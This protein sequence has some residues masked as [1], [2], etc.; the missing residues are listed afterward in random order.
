MKKL[1]IIALVFFLFSGCSSVEHQV[2][3]NS[4]GGTTIEK[5]LIPNGKTVT[6]PID[7]LKDGY[8]FICWEL[9]NKEFNFSTKVSKDLILTAKWE[10]SNLKKYKVTFD[11]DGKIT[12]NLIDAGNPVNEPEKPIKNGYLFLG[13]YAKDE[14]NPHNFDLILTSDLALSAKFQKIDT[15]SSSEYS[16]QTIFVTDLDASV[17]KKEIKV[18]ETIQINTSIVPDNASNKTVKFNSSNNRLATVSQT[19]LIKGIR[20]GEVTISI[21]TTDSSE[22]SKSLKITIIAK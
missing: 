4:N 9:D 13:W 19:G 3:F 5:Q 21:S 14:T 16:E 10:A 22:I 20:V 12:E 17:E 11:L 2:K 7:P 6:K 1:I 8:K 18:G 15:E